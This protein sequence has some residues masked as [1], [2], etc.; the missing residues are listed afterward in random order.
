MSAPILIV[1]F[2][3][4]GVDGLNLISPT[5]DSD[6]IAARPDVLRVMRS[7]D[8]TGHVL[9][10]QAA[11]VDFRF[12]PR[13]KGLWE[14]FE[15]KELAV[16]H[17]AGLTDG[18]RSHFDAEAKMERAA[19]SGSA[20]GWLGRWIEME[21]PNGI[22][23][24]LATGAGA[25]DSLSGARDVAVAQALEDLIIAQ[26]H[27]LAPVLRRRLSEG[28]GAHPLIGAPIAKLIELSGSLE[29]HI[30]DETTG[31][32][33]EYVPAVTY[34]DTDLSQ[35]FKT[36][37]RA[38]KL[39]LGLRVGTIDFGGWDTHVNQVDDFPQL[40]DRLSTAL[41]AFW[42]D[43]ET[44]QDRTTIVVMSEF[45]RRLRSNTAGGTDHGYGNAM[46]VLGAGVKGGR[47]LGEWPGLAHDA[48]DAGADLN[49]TTDYRHVLADV[50]TARMGATDLLSV[51]PAFT[52]K[53]L[54]IFS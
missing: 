19:Q 7:G 10:D 26:G 35:A 41:Q 25:P 43:L 8:E 24:I 15:A 51:F 45:G 28:F 33:T 52:A 44:H 6:Y 2:L 18:T 48:L 20:G 21:R 5:A 3:R 27:G 50:L 53:S 37:A 22:M 31:D 11:D 13:A 46:M 36:V 1:V 38:I 16:I 40:V 23:P 29:R 17:A 32:V 39:D 9:S 42:R 12:H 30:V 47:M 14:M 49:I 34:P 4:G 54:D